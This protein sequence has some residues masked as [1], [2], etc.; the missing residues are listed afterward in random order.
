MNTVI[1]KIYKL[2]DTNEVIEDSDYT[3]N[4]DDKIIDIKNMILKKTFDNKFNSL[5][6]E[7]ITDRIY[8]DF[9]K[10]SFEK[11]LLSNNM[12]NYKL[13]QFTSENR[14]FSFIVTPK[15]ITIV[16]KKPVESNFLKKIIKEDMKKNNHAT[17]IY[18]EDFPP[19]APT[20]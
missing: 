2:N 14:T 17:F 3:F 12:D 19:L 18:D 4:L 10:L 11:G 13:S 1:F 6:L 20:K 7:N 5:D 16:K 8:K 15:N 9:G